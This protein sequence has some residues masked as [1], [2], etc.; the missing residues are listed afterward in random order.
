M[1]LILSYLLNRFCPSLFSIAECEKVVQRVCSNSPEEHLQPFKDKMEAFVLSGENS[2]QMNS[3]KTTC[4]LQNLLRSP[5]LV[6]RV[7][8]IIGF[9]PPPA[10]VSQSHLV[11]V[12]FLLC[13]G[14]W[15]DPG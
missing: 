4:S 15:R 12:G 5:L 3:A 7:A 10:Q 8:P 6:L 9:I 11:S 13:L 14:G 2:K 1:L